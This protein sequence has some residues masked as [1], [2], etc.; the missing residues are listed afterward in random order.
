[1]NN[2]DD[3]H[4]ST[5]LIFLVIIS[6]SHVYKL[7]IICTFSIIILSI[8]IKKTLFF[9]LKHNKREVNY[10][11]FISSTPFKITLLSFI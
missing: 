4:S 11:S 6:P 3:R 1:M 8:N 9:V 2:N 5:I 10:F 7:K